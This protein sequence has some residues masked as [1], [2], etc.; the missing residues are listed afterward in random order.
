MGRND[1]KALRK[2]IKM[3]KDLG[4]EMEF[5]PDNPEM[6]QYMAEM[7]EQF[8]FDNEIPEKKRRKKKHDS[9]SR[10]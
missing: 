10:E 1:N 7:V 8:L 5:D 4:L 2:L 3:Y 6:N 9:I